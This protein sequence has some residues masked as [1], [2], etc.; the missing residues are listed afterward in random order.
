MH[1]ADILAHAFV[2]PYVR[3]EV[4]TFQIQAMAIHNMDKL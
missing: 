1:I 3:I 2:L 4:M